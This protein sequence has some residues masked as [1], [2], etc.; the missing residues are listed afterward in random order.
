MRRGRGRGRPVEEIDRVEERAGAAALRSEAAAELL[1]LV[2]ALARGLGRGGRVGDGRP[3]GGGQVRPS[4]REASRGV[5]AGE[6]EGLVGGPARRRHAAGGGRGV[7]GGRRSH[8][9]G[10]EEE[11]EA[12]A[13]AVVVMVVPQVSLVR[14]G[15]SGAEE[16]GDL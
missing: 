8:R 11:A 6:R 15:I 12:E 16:G 1:D 5:G 4:H 2:A 10:G 3:V 13:E 7:G 9:N 14:E